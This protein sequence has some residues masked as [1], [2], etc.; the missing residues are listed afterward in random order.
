LEQNK[1]NNSYKIG[2]RRRTTGGFLG[3]NKILSQLKEGVPRRRIGLIVE[4]APA[5]GN[6][7]ISFF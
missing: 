4:G 6:N 5:R 2:K 7:I 1:K 3:A